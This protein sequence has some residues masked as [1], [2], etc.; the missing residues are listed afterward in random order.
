M[1][2]QIKIDFDKILNNLKLSKENVY[3]RKKKTLANSLK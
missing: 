2:E 3:L 1:I